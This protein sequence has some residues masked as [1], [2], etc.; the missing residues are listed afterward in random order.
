LIHEPFI[1]FRLLELLVKLYLRGE[2]M[3]KVLVLR[4]MDVPSLRFWGVRSVT[5]YLLH[6]I[7]FEQMLVCQ[8]VR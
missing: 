2:V 3:M 1:P 7:W 8:Y 6:C 4:L 5:K